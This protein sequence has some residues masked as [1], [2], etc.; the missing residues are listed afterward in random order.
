MKIKKFGNF[1]D[2]STLLIVDVQKSFKDFFSD[3]YLHNL[4][5]YCKEF[6]RVYQVF[7]NHV[8]GKNVD[9]DYL[10][11]VNPDVQVH[12]L[13]TFPKQKDIIEKRY[14]Y[15]VE[16]GFYKR[17]LSKDLY[18]KISS[19]EKENKLKRGQYF[20]T[21][22][23]TLLVFIGN[24]HNWFHCPKKLLE[25]FKECSGKKIT[26][27]GGARD[28]CLTDIEITAKALGVDVNIN[29]LYTYSAGQCY[30]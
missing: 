5:N 16:I 29:F 26:I 11:D 15:N 25:L 28:E 30:F 27:V 12:D 1:K 23:G 2:E 20:E 14:N 22:E 4:K 7:D 6:D 9:K 13:Y 19:L 18:K 8:D 3:S 24:N 21:E 17:I 10:Y